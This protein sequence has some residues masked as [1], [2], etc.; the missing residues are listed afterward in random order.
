MKMNYSSAIDSR[1]RIT[2]PHKIRHNLGLSAGD[3]IEFVVEG[4]EVVLRP[5][6]SAKPTNPWLRNPR[7]R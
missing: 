1:G 7:N 3:R 2:L 5:V 4:A 6:R